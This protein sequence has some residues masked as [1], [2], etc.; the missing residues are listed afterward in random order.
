M[1]LFFRLLNNRHQL[2]L[3]HSSPVISTSNRL[4]PGI[5]A[6]ELDMAHSLRRSLHSST[7]LLWRSGSRHLRV[8][9]GKNCFVKQIIRLSVIIRVIMVP[10]LGTA[11]TFIG[12][13][14]LIFYSRK[15]EITFDRL[16]NR[17][18]NFKWETISSRENSKWW[19]TSKYIQK[20]V[21]N[22]SPL[23]TRQSRAEGFYNNFVLY[24]A[25]LPSI[26]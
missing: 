21:L 26:S 2:I 8:F 4:K 5:R 24:L 7:D 25:P 15:N 1:S 17:M 23:H 13:A 22:F 3:N 18:S 11:R 20:G 19:F 9:L 10:N 16:F 12:K 6:P 14:W